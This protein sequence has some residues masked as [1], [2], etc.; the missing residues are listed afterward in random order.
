MYIMPR[1]IR[2]GS[3]RCNQ[4]NLISSGL[5]VNVLRALHRAARLVAKIPIVRCGVDRGIVELDGVA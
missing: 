1:S 2:T 3:V 5:C 4:C